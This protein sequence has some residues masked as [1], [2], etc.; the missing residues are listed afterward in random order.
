MPEGPEVRAVAD[1]LQILVNKM[2]NDMVVGENAKI[3]GELIT[4]CIITEVTA[5]GK[6]LVIRTG[7]DQFIVVSFGMT[8]V[9]RF[10]EG[11]YSHVRFPICYKNRILFKNLYF[12][13]L[14][15]FGN[16]KITDQLDLSDLGPDLL[17][18]ALN[19]M[20]PKDEWK[21]IF[22]NHKPS[23]MNKE[24]CQVLLDQSVVSG[25]GNYL[26]SEILYV[27]GI[28]PDRKLD[29]LTEDEFEKLRVEAHRIIKESYSH[30][31]LT[32][33]NFINPNGTMGN[34][35]RLIYN[36]SHDPQGHKV[37]K[38]KSKDAR[39]TFYCSQCQK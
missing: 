23:L 9:F 25:I 10:T 3:E 32:I 20:I 26:K 24:M 38:V 35:P 37:I 2:I 31:G 7:K 27:A 6:K 13:D 19:E 16:I 28:L 11:K 30:G 15:R 5:Y 18:H 4:P 39:G 8:G 34:Y 29:S 1:T 21:N 33:E 17:H 22:A 36:R 12:D 14:R